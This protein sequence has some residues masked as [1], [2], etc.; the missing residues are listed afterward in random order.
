MGY[1]LIFVMILIYTGQTFFCKL[2]LDKYPGQSDMASPV[3]SVVS[4]SAVA[5]VTFIWSG[6]RFSFDPLILLLGVINAAIIFSYNYVLIATSRRGPY[7]VLS[8][9]NASGGI[10]MPIIV[11][12]V[13]RDFNHW[14]WFVI[15]FILLAVY[16]V[17]AKKQ[18]GSTKTEPSFFLFCPLLAAVNGSYGAMLDLQK[19]LTEQGLTGDSGKGEMLIIT[20]A[21]VALASLIFGFIKRKGRF[22]G[23]FKQ[24]KLSFAFLLIS[25]ACTAVAANLLTTLLEGGLVNNTTLLTFKQSGILVFSV[26][27]SCLFLKEKLSLKNILGIVLMCAGLVTLSFM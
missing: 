5:L 4:A 12:V 10:L 27:A 26:L 18:E 6:F 15:A 16:L 23:D 1:L 21:C 22:V 9:F 25:S 13:F 11:A 14:K 2:Y 17:S 3:F 8:V 19:R 24:T 7:S 20:Y